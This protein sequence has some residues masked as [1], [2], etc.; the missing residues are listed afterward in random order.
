LVRDIDEGEPDVLALRQ[1]HERA[2]QEVRK[3]ELL[4]M[5]DSPR[6]QQ[7]IEIKSVAD[8]SLD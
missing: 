7:Y 3:R 4:R 1:E 5:L 6:E 2:A 8:V